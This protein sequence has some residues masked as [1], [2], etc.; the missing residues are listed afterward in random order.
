LQLETAEKN[1]AWSLQQSRAA[2]E[3]HRILKGTLLWDLDREY[4][5]RLWQQQRSIAELDEALAVA[6]DSRQ[7]TDAARSSVPQWLEK[8]TRRIDR[9]APRVE[10]M[11][12]KI[13]TLVGQQQQQLQVLVARE[14]SAQKE[15][16]ATYR[17][18]A[19][20]ALA[21]IYDRAT[22]AASDDSEATE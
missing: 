18:Q 13:G 17:V 12:A 19:R 10:A 15:R 3:K 22:V 6:H 2:R 14:F 7:R 1:P 8:Y 11:R 9:L 21:T 5:Y 20:F 16:L 4:K